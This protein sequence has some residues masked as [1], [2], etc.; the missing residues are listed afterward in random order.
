V[1]TLKMMTYNI[2]GNAASRRTDHLEKI[3]EVIAKVS[4]DIAGLQEVH[5]RTRKLPIDQ[6]E[7]VAEL[8]G[9][10][11]AFGRSCSMDG[12][13]YGNAVLTR[14]N[15]T[16]SEITSLPGGGEPRSIMRADVDID[17]TPLSFFVTHL[18]AWGRLKRRDRLAQIAK[19]GAITTEAPHPHI[20]VGDFN[21]PPT[22]EEIRVLM[23][24]GHLRASDPHQEFTYRLLRQRLDYVFCDP[25]WT[26]L[27]SEVIRTGPSDHWPVVVELE[28]K[29]S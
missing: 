8:T 12:G 1:F 28:L 5:C 22:T 26:V 10:T 16:G 29:D 23:A 20:L 15:V 3:A 19:V 21:V 11:L 17:G 6:G 4:P 2:Q 9:L 27:K 7:R 18:T 13:D 24:Q 25:R 14:G